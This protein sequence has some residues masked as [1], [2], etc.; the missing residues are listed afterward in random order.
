[1]EIPTSIRLAFDKTFHHQ[2]KSRD[3]DEGMR[4]RKINQPK[5]IYYVASVAQKDLKRA[6]GHC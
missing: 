5:A 4:F 1:M 3:D 6:S 2:I